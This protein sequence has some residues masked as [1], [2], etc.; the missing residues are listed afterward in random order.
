MQRLL[1]TTGPLAD[2]VDFPKIP[3]PIHLFDPPMQ[4]YEYTSKEEKSHLNGIRK[5]CSA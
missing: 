2:Q 5:A 1:R 3:S 4:H